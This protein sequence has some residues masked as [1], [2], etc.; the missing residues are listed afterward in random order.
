MKPITFVAVSCLFAVQVGLLSVFA[1][2][3]NIV[4]TITSSVTPETIVGAMAAVVQVALPRDNGFVATFVLTGAAFV[5]HPADTADAFLKLVR[6]QRLIVVVSCNGSPEAVMAS[7]SVGGASNPD[8]A[9]IQ[10]LATGA[11][12]GSVIVSRAIVTKAD[13]ATHDGVI[14]VGVPVPLPLE[15]FC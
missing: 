4:T 12:D 7:D 13:V 14:D 11:T 3:A 15:A 9:G 10:T 6:K 1:C 5:A 2:V 8:L